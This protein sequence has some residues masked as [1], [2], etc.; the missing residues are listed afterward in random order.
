VWEVGTVNASGGGFTLCPINNQ[1]GNALWL[2]YTAT[3]NYST[4]LIYYFN[5]NNMATDGGKLYRYNLTTTKQ[6]LIA[7]DLTNHM[8][9]Q[10]QD[11]RGNAQTNRTH[12]S[13]V[14]VWMEFA[15]YQYPLTKVGPG[16]FYDY[17][18]M[19]FKIT[20]HVPDGP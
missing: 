4:G 17:Y 11:Y 12:K 18:K 20:S 1:K 2:S 5:T 9:F 15:Q 19:E 13:V 7:Q 16:Y 8:Y 6:A 3:T 14:Q 10:V